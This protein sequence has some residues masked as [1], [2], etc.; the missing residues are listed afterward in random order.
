MERESVARKAAKSVDSSVE[1]SAAVWAALKVGWL[2]KPRAVH[3]DE[4]TVGQLELM[5]AVYLADW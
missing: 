3:S 5:L 4:L 1:W 2:V